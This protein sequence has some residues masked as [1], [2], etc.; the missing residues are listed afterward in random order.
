MGQ[1]DDNEIIEIFNKLA[2]L[3][4]SNS[5]EQTQNFEHEKAIFRKYC[6]KFIKKYE[7]KLLTD[8]EKNCR[9]MEDKN[10]LC[11]VHFLKK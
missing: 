4:K 3:N 9:Q 11:L 7:N 10:R 5:S 1:L 8:Y 2:C 6:H